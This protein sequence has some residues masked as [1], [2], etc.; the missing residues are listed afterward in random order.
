MSYVKKPYLNPE[1]WA[2]RLKGVPAFLIGNGPSVEDEDLSILKDYFTIGSNRIFYIFDPTIL[3]WQDLALWTK[4]KES[5]KKCKAIK[6]VRESAD[7]EGGFYGFSLQGRDSRIS[8]NPRILYGRGSSGSLMYQLAFA[9]GCD[10]IFLV[11]MDCK[12]RGEKTDFYGKNPMHRK[13]TLQY[14]V[15]ALRFI[16][17]SKCRRNIVNC[18]DSEVFSDRISLSEAVKMCGEKKYSRELLKNIIL[19]DNIIEK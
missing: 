5:I 13:H 6:Y 3:L 1:K 9:L 8:H 16:K 11:G 7:T 12:Y 17:D 10:P 14:C 18:S 15:K 19:D 4:E 2:M